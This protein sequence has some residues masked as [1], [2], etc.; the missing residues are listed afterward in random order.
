[1]IRF[2]LFGLSVILGRPDPYREGFKDGWQAGLFAAL[3][4]Q[5]RTASERLASANEEAELVRRGE[6][7][8]PKR[9]TTCDRPEL[10]TDDPRVVRLDD[11]RASLEMLLRRPPPKPKA[12]PKWLPADEPT[13]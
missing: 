1:M 11:V 6:L 10:P 13:A 4:V 3:S 12:I 8:P 2:R 9:C 7:P 5:Q